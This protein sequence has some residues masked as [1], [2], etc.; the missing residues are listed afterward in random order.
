MTFPDDTQKA[1]IFGLLADQIAFL[2]AREK[3]PEFAGPAWAWERGET[4]AAIAIH[5]I[6]EGKMSRGEYVN[7]PDW[8]AI[9]RLSGDRAVHLT[10]RGSDAKWFGRAREAAAR[11]AE[12]RAY[13][14]LTEAIETAVP[15]ICRGQCLLCGH[16][17]VLSDRYRCYNCDSAELTKAAMAWGFVKARR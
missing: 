15:G 2:S 5:R 9:R 17:F 6:I 12:G 1:L 10:M 16:K 13:R 3:S 7:E 14:A 4:K 8:D 11:F